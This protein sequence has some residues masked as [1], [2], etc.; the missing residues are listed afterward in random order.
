MSWNRLLSVIVAMIYLVVAYAAHGLE[1][2][3]RVAI[4]LIL[5]LACIWFADAMGSYTGPTP[6]GAITEKTPGGLVCFGGWLVLLLPVI[7]VIV[8]ACASR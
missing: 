4:F 8:A 1:L 7:A 3:G 2:V 5:P 6:R